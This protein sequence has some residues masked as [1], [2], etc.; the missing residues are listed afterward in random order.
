MCDSVDVELFV[1]VCLC[2]SSQTLC[3]ASKKLSPKLGTIQTISAM[4]NAPNRTTKRDDL[5]ARIH[6]VF[7]DNDIGD[8]DEDNADDD[9]VWRVASARTECEKDTSVR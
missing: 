9:F 7:G 4:E 1:S 6:I 8:D 2:M 3:D 5:V